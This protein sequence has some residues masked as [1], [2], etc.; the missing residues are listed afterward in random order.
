MRV[1]FYN[2]RTGTEIG[3]GEIDTL[4]DGTTDWTFHHHEFVPATGTT[5]FDVQLSSSSPVTGTAKSWFDDAG[6]IAWSGW[7][8]FN[9]SETM[10]TPNDYYWVQ[11]KSTIQAS[12]ATVSYTETRYTDVSTPVKEQGSSHPSAFKLLQNYPN[13][14]NPSTSIR[15]T[16]PVAGY[17]TLRV[18]NVLGQEAATLVDEIRGAGDHIATWKPRGMA[19][20]VYL[21]RLS[22]GDF[23]GIRKM[24]LLK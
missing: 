6:I 12:T 9:P 22:A 10:S 20:G 13:P 21:Y 8:P 3:T 7:K 14:F 15:Y 16:L 17:V 18:Y 23:T 4:I 19:S 5:F 1:K 11:V 2:S 24:M